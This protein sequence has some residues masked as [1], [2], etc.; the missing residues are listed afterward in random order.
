MIINAA[1]SPSIEILEEREAVSS[2][3]LTLIVGYPKSAVADF[4][5]EKA[6]ELGLSEIHFFVGDHSQSERSAASLEKRLSRLYRVRDAALKQ[7][8]SLTST[9]ISL[10]QKLSLA[11]E[12]VHP[13]KALAAPREHRLC[14]LAPSVHGA[15][16]A[17]RSLRLT[18]LSLAQSVE[19]TAP[20]EKVDES[21][22]SSVLVGP[23][24]GL[25]PNELD[26]ITSYAYVMTS[27]GPNV[28]RVETAVILACG[29]VSALSEPE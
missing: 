29:M 12:A 18:L 22:D 14:C 17:R 13:S 11:L 24:G 3:K 20:L 23:E 2:A 28:L 21:V 9:S 7:S 15:E 8:A 16:L 26:T 5:V 10:H 1:S 25:S 6:T 19:A 4:I 27:L